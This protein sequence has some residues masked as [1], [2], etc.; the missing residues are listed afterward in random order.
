M[1]FYLDESVLEVFHEAA[2]KKD[3]YVP[4]KLCYDNKNSQLCYTRSEGVEKLT[5]RKA[6][7]RDLGSIRLI[8]SENSITNIKNI[9]NTNNKGFLVY[10][11]SDEQYVSYI[12][13]CQHF[14]V[15]ESLGEI[16][17]FLL[18]VNDNDL[19]MGKI[20]HQKMGKY[21]TNQFLVIEQVCIK[22]TSQKKGYGQKLYD[23]LMNRTDKD[24]FLAVVLEPYNDSAVR[25]HNKLGF[26]QLF[27][28]EPEDQMKRGIFYWNNYQSQPRYDKEIILKQYE[29][30]MELYKHEDLLNWSKMHNLFYIS[31]GLFAVISILASTFTE[32]DQLFYIVLLI[33]SVLGMLSSVLFQ[34]TI[35]NGIQYLLK[36]KRTVEELE[37]M[38]IHL[39]GADV[40]SVSFDRM[41]KRF[42]TSPTGRAMKV[43]PILVTSIWAILFL[44]SLT[45]ILIIY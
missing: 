18:A 20:L 29:H 12:R 39:G 37:K 10:P 4:Y 25:F 40:V 26:R 24:I 32:I 38:L 34:I 1:I 6:E 44:V 42:K 43:I 9:K 27:T 8:S 7:E 11:L 3:D 35:Y 17:G 23:F 15:L 45:Q 19:D 30:A 2:Q 33:L 16:H 22:K 5:I 31:G 21:S 13:S 36:R 14:Y 41:A 28:V